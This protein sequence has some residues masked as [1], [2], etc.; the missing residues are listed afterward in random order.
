MLRAEPSRIAESLLKR[1][2]PRSE[3]ETLIGELKEEFHHSI[4][5]RMGAVG[6]KL[7]FWKESLSLMGGYIRVLLVR[8]NSRDI[9]V[10]M[11]ARRMRRKWGKQDKGKDRGNRLDSLIQD[12]RHGYRSLRKRPSFTLA[13]ML[14]MA[15]GIGVTFPSIVLAII[16]AGA[17]HGSYLFDPNLFVDI[18]ER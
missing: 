8:E 1:V 14:T 17:G 16:S 15:I 2:L 3:H 10:V 4:A 12:I 5:P 11:N 9:S 7:W 6:A 13:A 18:S